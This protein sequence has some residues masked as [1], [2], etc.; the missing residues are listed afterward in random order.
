MTY[1]PQFALPA[2]PEGFE[3]QASEYTFDSTNTFDQEVQLMADGSTFE[4]LYAGSD[5]S[6][7][8]SICRAVSVD[9]GL[10]WTDRAKLF[11]VGD[12]PAGCNDLTAPTFFRG[13]NGFHVFFQSSTDLGEHNS[14][15]HAISRDMEHWSINWPMFSPQGAGFESVSTSNANVLQ[16]GSKLYLFYCGASAPG[17]AYGLNDRIAVAILDGTTP[18]GEGV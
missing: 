5:D 16:F 8:R 11:G 3:Y 12:L 17:A 10:T 6:L 9:N 2:A 7:S 1:R 13:P 4:M 14:I 18:A 15:G